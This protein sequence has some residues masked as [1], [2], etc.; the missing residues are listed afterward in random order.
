MSKKIPIGLRIRILFANHGKAAFYIPLF[1]IGIPVSLGVIYS[2]GSF[3]G[4][5]GAVFGVFWGI[6]VAR[7]VAPVVGNWFGGTIFY[8]KSYLKTV[9]EILSPIKGM[10]AREEYDDA[11]DELNELLDEK[12]FSPEPYLI[13]VEI[14]ENDLKDHHRAM[15]LI[16]AYF[17]QE[18]VYAFDENIEMLLLYADICAEHNYLQKAQRILQQELSRKGYSDEKRKR[19]QARLEAISSFES[20]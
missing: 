4:I 5:V 10:I 19:F 15:E 2:F 7:L 20:S 1:V 3:A 14:Y 8:P 12:P 11:I 17:G 6:I 16:E 18:K 9:P 13:L